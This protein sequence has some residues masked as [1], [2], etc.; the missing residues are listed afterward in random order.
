[1]ALKTRQT[2]KLS[3]K[4]EESKVQG[5]I[6][7]Y[8]HPHFTRQKGIHSCRK[9]SRCWYCLR[10]RSL[11]VTVPLNEKP[12][13]AHLWPLGTINSW[14]WSMALPETAY[15]RIALSHLSS[16]PSRSCLCRSPNKIWQRNWIRIK[17]A[18]GIN[19]SPSYRECFF[20]TKA[21]TEY[22]KHV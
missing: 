20:G 8:R 13:V 21:G 10:N 7:S 15:I 12:R 4:K 2:R 9:N 3:T 16:L 19:S 5:K 6:S 14:H 11:S 1:M 18:W 22:W 17:T